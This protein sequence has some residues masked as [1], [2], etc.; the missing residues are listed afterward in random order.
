MNHFRQ[1][2]LAEPTMMPGA[3]SF[4]KERVGD[5]YIPGLSVPHPC[6]ARMEH[7]LTDPATVR[8]A[9]KAANTDYTGRLPWRSM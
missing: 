6:Y 4:P 3:P 2:G 9:N 5:R 8:L 1:S 7:L